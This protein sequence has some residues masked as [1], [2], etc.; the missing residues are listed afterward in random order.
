MIPAAAFP[1]FVARPPWWG[2]DLQTL[3]NAVRRDFSNLDSASAEQLEFLDAET[4]DVLIGTL[5][6]PAAPAID[7]RRRPLII[8]I[9]GLT[10]DQDSRYM[11]AAARHM[12]AQGY[13]VLRL[14]LR[15]AGP[16]PERCQGHYHAGRSEDLRLVLG[17]MDGRLAANGIVLV[18]FSLGGNIMLKYLAERG[19]RA[20]VL[21]AV[22]VSAPIDL[23]ASQVRLMARRNRWYH[24]FILREMKADISRPHYSLSESERA[25]L[26]SIGTVLEFD[27]HFV[28]PRNG[29]AGADDYYA[30][31]SAKPLLGAIR[32]P[33]L[34][35][36][37]RN[38]PW[39]PAA[40]YDD[41]PRTA[42]PGLTLLMPKGG[43]HAGFHGIGGGVP[44]HN[45]CI[46]LVAER[47]A[48]ARSA[49]R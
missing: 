46:A 2:G 34:L 48:G 28:A 5:N 24:D 14:N 44:W 25:R 36:H 43:G 7:D 8:L 19:A 17:K 22:S 4:G 20:P 10:G 31:G 30:R 13:P 6:R 1:R 41:V 29:F 33:T 11:R 49:R 16:S 27:E 32:T 40:I 18:G 39:I 12:L 45:R 42:N 9:H 23:K 38:D 26:E 35:I 3:R 37:A 21:G 47:L 15:G